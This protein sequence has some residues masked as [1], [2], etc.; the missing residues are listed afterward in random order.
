[1]GRSSWGGL[2]AD[3]ERFGSLC[4]CCV[5]LCLSAC[6]RACGFDVCVCA[7]LHSEVFRCLV[8]RFL[9]PLRRNVPLSCFDA[10]RDLIRCVPRRRPEELSNLEGLEAPRGR[11]SS[12]Q[13]GLCFQRMMVRWGTS[14]TRGRHEVLVGSGFFET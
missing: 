11:Q 1:M 2:L 9:F 3:T 13:N 5:F 4:A 6:A 8:S 14:H 7:F 10:S 12:C